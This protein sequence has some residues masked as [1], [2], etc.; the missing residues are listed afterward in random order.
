MKV[1]S[2]RGNLSKGKPLLSVAACWSLYESS[3]NSD[4]PLVG[5]HR[6]RPALVCRLLPIQTRWS[7]GCHRSRPALVGRLSADRFDAGRSVCSDV[8][9][10]P[11]AAPVGRLRVV[12]PG[13]RAGW[14]LSARPPHRHRLQLASER[15]HTVLRGTARQPW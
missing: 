15:R 3:R 2:R 12:S 6:S 13:R 7:A 11:L 1:V 14:L 9:G 8:T 4:L 5:C 10:G